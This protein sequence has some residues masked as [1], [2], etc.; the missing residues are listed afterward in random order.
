[1]GGDPTSPFQGLVPFSFS[2]AQGVALGYVTSP[3]RGLFAAPLFAV[4][5]DAESAETP[6]ERGAIAILPMT[7]TGE[8]PAPRNCLCVPGVLSGGIIL[9]GELL[10]QLFDA[11]KAECSGCR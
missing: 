4:C 3:L 2:S 7:L 1:M 10:W 11:V 8:P 6:L 9:R 5:L